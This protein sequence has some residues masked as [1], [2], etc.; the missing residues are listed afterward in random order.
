MTTINLYKGYDG[1][2]EIILLE[3]TSKGE[4]IFKVQLL[5]FHFDEILSLI[6]LGNYSQNS[7]VYNYFK[8]EGWHDGKWECTGI[9]EFRNQLVLLNIPVNLDNVF[10]AIKQICDSALTNQNKL[11]IDLD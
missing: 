2:Q 7:V 4:E 3:E 5:A 6:P 8:A 10:N 11:F 1:H 9:Q